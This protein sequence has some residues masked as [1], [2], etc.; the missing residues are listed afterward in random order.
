LIQVRPRGL[1]R[2]GH[3]L[4]SEVGCAG[5]ATEV[6]VEIIDPLEIVRVGSGSAALKL[7]KSAMSK[8]RNL[9]KKTYAGLETV[10][11]A[12]RA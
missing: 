7:L 2:I 1:A 4:I 10:V 9:L 12:G 8:L 6:V 5:A 3:G 11:G